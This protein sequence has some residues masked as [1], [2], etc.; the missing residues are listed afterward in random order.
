MRSPRPPPRRAHLCRFPICGVCSKKFELILRAIGSAGGIPPEPPIRPP[1][2]E[3]EAKR[4]ISSFSAR[5]ASYKNHSDF[6]FGGKFFLFFLFWF[7]K[8]SATKPCSISCL[9]FSRRRNMN[10]KSP[11]IFLISHLS[12]RIRIW[13]QFYIYASAK[14]G[15]NS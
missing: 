12:F 8:C 7:S 6:C 14:L 1:R 11:L 5:F 9:T 15:L 2:L 3:A 10:Q 13:F 4:T